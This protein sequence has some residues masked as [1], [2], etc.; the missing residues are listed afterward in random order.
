MNDIIQYYVSAK[1]ELKILIEIGSWIQN[2]Q[3]QAKID[4]TF[5]E[6][7]EKYFQ[8]F[9]KLSCAIK[10]VQ[11]KDSDFKGNEKTNWRPLVHFAAGEVSAPVPTTG[12]EVQAD[13]SRVIKAWFERCFRTNHKTSNFLQ[14]SLPEINVQKNTWSKPNL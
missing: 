13:D 2:C 12:N 7:E 10:L 9:R 1:G 11:K 6:F 5:L 3:D 4:R 14:I 8:V